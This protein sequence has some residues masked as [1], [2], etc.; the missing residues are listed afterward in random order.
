MQGIHLKKPCFEGIQCCSNSLVEFM[1]P[2]IL[3]TMLNILYFYISIGW[4]GGWRS[5]VG[6]G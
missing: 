4:G 2:V 5:V 1:V 6:N 3:L